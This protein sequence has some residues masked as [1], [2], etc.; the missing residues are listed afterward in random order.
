MMEQDDYVCSS[1]SADS[2]ICG[3]SDEIYAEV[4]EDEGESERVLVPRR[5]VRVIE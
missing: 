1:S 3:S 4:V 2:V 5:E